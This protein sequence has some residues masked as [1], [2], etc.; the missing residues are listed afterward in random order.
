MTDL[1]TNFYKLLTKHSKG[2]EQLVSDPA[3]FATLPDSWLVVVTDIQGSTLAI[4][5]GKYRA[6]NNIAASSIVAMVNVAQKHGIEIPY[7]FGGDGATALIPA[8]LWPQVSQALLA[9]KAQSWQQQLK[10]RVGSISLQDLTQQGFN[11]SVAKLEL[12]PGFIQPVFL[13]N[14]LE[15]AEKIIKQDREY[16]ISGDGDAAELDLSGLQCRWQP[17]TPPNNKDEVVCLLVSTIQ[18]DNR[19]KVYS[20]ILQKVEDLYGD[21]WQ[22]HP[23]SLEKMHLSRNIENFLDDQWV[24]PTN[25]ILSYLKAVPKL[26]LSTLFIK[27]GKLNVDI[28]SANEYVRSVALR[29]DCLKL[30][31]TL[32]MIISGDSAQRKQLIQYLDNLEVNGKIVYGHFVSKASLLTCFVQDTKQNHIHFI[33][34][35]DGGYTL[36]A[37]EWKEKQVN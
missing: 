21:Y 25:G 37:K 36:A 14:A 6:V 12:T 26:L 34:G 33:D 32:K 13:G 10:L 17:I 7:I 4:T 15:I 28:N 11:L 31:T 18:A 5:A 29:T 19:E 22:R 23:I 1:S 2:L 20:Q 27:L 8:E 24:M 3:N 35:A 9:L 16:Q 30:D